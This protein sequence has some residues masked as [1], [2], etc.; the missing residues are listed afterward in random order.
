MVECFAPTHTCNTST[1]QVKGRM[2][3]NGLGLAFRATG[4]ELRVSASSFAG[5]RFHN[6]Q[7]DVTGNVATRPTI[8][9]DLL[10][11]I[12]PNQNHVAGI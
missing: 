11:L 6:H 3:Y 5:L 4:S 9:Q 2:M 8:K 12:S 7:I 1:Y 10:S